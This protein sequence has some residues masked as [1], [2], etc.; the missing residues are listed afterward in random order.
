MGKII[1]R[2][3]KNTRKG[4]E[5]LNRVGILTFHN[6]KNRNFG[7]ILQSYAILKMLE[8][9]VKNVVLLDILPFKLSYK[10]KVL[11]RIEGHNFKKFSDKFLKI[12]KECCNKKELN[13]KIDIFIVGSD[14]VWRPKM[15]VDNMKNYYFDFVDDN[16]TKIAYAASFGVDFWEGGKELTEKIKPLAQR[17]DHVSVREESGI[18]ICNDT[19]GI[20]AVCVLD[21]TLMIDKKDYQPILDDWKDESHKKK[22]YIAHMLLDDTVELREESNNIGKYLKSEI[23][24][25]KGKDR[26]ILG[27]TITFYNKVSQWLTYVKDTELVITDSFHCTVFSLIFNKKFVVV[28]NPERGTARLENLLGIVGLKDRFFTNIKDVLKS[29]ILDKNIDYVEVEKKLNVHREYSMNFL[30]KAL[31]ESNE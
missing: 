15:K 1:F 28:A 9:N 13:K 7:A 8:K 31:G 10:S 11:G 16:K 30:K 19:F 5:K 4:R 20:D 17:F 26:K 14:Q 2:F 6:Y 24:Y 18:K 29:G 12:N 21:P 23:N 22:K 3:K 27:K 25:I